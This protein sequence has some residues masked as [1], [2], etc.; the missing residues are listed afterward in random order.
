[1]PHQHSTESGTSDSTQA[2]PAFCTQVGVPAA[3]LPKIQPLSL[4]STIGSPPKAPNRPTVI[5]SGMTIC[6][7]VTPKLPRPAFSPSAVPC[8]RFGKKVLMLDIELAKLP[9]PTPDHSAISWKVHSGQSL[10]CSTM[11]VPMAG[12]SSMAVVRKMVL[13]PPARRMRKDAGMRIV[14]PEMPAMAVS[15]NSSAWVN[16]KPRLSICTVMIPHMPQTAKP[17]SSAGTEIQRLR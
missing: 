1:M 9:P 5:T 8:S 2:K 3:I 13:R 11:P 6:I 4:T 12:A 7:V 16:G 15:V 10:C 17:H 14:A